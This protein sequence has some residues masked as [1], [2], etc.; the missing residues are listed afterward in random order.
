MIM[1]F[2]DPFDTLLDL[3]RSLEASLASDWLQDLTTS[4]GPFPP[5]N[6]FQQGDDILAIIELPGVNKSDLQIQAKDNSIRIFGK[7]TVDYPEEAS[8]HRRERASGEFDR[9]LSVPVQI[10]SN[11]I[12]A[13]YRDG[14]LAVFLPRAESDKPRS[15]KIT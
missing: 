14:I 5:I 13:E 10:D 6:V 4:R 2:A 11:G 12:R 7:K 9:T 1:G 3:Q 8:L 15:I